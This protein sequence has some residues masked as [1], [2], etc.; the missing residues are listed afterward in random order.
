MR[1]R[2][3]LAIIEKS[4][5][6]A[7]REVFRWALNQLRVGIYEKKENGIV[8]DADYKLLTDVDSFRGINVDLGF[9]FGDFLIRF[10]EK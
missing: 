8:L 9:T 6:R 4:K 10:R 7:R 5:K 2:E 1:T 3:L